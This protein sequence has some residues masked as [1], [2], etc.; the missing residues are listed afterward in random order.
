MVG[1]FGLPLLNVA[2]AAG[3]V[4]RAKSGGDHVA[5]RTKEERDDQ[6][7]YRKRPLSHG[8]DAFNK[9]P[10][11]AGIIFDD[12]AARLYFLSTIIGDDIVSKRPK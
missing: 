12:Q 2:V 8:S 10:T 6:E 4:T 11:I 9:L 5:P 1:L 7:G 3:Q